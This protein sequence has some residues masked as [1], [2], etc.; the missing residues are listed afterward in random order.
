MF[1]DLI[2]KTQKAV[3]ALGVEVKVHMLFDED[4]NDHVLAGT[5]NSRIKFPFMNELHRDTVTLTE[6]IYRGNTELAFKLFMGYFTPNR[7]A[8]MLATDEELLAF[9]GHPDTFIVP[10]DKL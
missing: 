8:H 7:V 1:E 9:E 6:R 5:Y 10:K 2:K 3:D 4:T